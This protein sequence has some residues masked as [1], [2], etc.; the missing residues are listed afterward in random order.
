[1]ND[2]LYFYFL[3][4]FYFLFSIYLYLELGFSITSQLLLSQISHIL[5][6]AVTVTVT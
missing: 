1:M 4:L 3:F 2:G 6:N 5:H